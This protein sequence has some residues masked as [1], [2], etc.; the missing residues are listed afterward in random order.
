VELALQNKL[1]ARGLRGI[2]ETIFKRFMFEIPSEE[3]KTKKLRITKKIAEEEWLA[4]ENLKY[5]S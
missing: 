4:V 3:K 5:A 1:G 2:C